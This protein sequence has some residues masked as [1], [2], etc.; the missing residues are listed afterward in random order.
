[1]QREIYNQIQSDEY[2][3]KQLLSLS[4]LLLADKLA[5]DLIFKDGIYL[6]FEELEKVLTSKNAL[7]E[8]ERCYDYVINECMV[9][10]SKFIYNYGEEHIGEVWGRHL[11]DQFRNE[12]IAVLKN[13]FNRICASGGFNAKA[14]LVWAGKNNLLWKSGDGTP[15]KTVS[16]GKDYKPRCY[17]IK[18]PQEVL[19]L[20]DSE[21][22]DDEE[23]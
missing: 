7:S 5:T 21:Q 14:F 11:T 2:E 13:P 12:Y 23:F 10:D 8:N 4:A 19:E 9:N 1:M 6:S 3:S 17:V 22:F 16:L 15:S 20:A 18:L